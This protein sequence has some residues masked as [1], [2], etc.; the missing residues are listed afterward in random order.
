MSIPIKTV[1]SQIANTKRN[2]G[3]YTTPIS[4]LNITVYSMISTSQATNIEIHPLQ[5]NTEN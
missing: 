4:N 1:L 2:S 3:A 5:T